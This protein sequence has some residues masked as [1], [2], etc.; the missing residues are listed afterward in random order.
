MV[1]IKQ[2]CHSKEAGGGA[3]ILAVGKDGTVYAHVALGL[4]LGT[5]NG[6]VL[7]ASGLSIS[8]RV[9]RAKAHMQPIL[10]PTANDDVAAVVGMLIKIGVPATQAATLRPISAAELEVETREE[11]LELG[12]LLASRGVAARDKAGLVQIYLLD[13]GELEGRLEQVMR[14][15]GAKAHRREKTPRE[16]WG[17]FQRV[18]APGLGLAPDSAKLIAARSAACRSDGEFTTY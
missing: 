5:C 10:N 9:A 2:D 11:A 15:C 17:A 6:E 12:K 1:L 14:L 4:S 3:V 7:F 8:C 16:L 13:E 18:G